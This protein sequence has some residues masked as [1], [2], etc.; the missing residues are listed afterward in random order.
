MSSSTPAL[1]D[2]DL[3]AFAARRADAGRTS[4]IVEARR[5]PVA[6][7]PALVHHKTTTN[8]RELLPAPPKARAGGAKK[9]LATRMGEVEAELKR[10]G[11]ADSARR[12]D[13]SGSFVVEVT[14]EQLRELAC[15]PSVQAI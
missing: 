8:P 5:P 14:P 4:V 15:S 3:V 9:A 11:L 7:P 13:L 2:N 10:L 12:N 1:R 6:P